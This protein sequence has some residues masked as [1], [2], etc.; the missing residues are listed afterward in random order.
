MDLSKNHSVQSEEFG[1]LNQK[2]IC[3]IILYWNSF[4]DTKNCIDSLLMDSKASH[5]IILVN[6]GSDNGS[7]ELLHQWL[8][9]QPGISINSIEYSLEK[10][11]Q[12]MLSS[13][14]ISQRVIESINIDR[15]LGFAG[16]NN[17]G[18]E[19]AL[20]RFGP[21]YIVLANNDTIIESGVISELTKRMDIERTIGV[22]GPTIIWTTRISRLHKSDI[23]VNAAHPV[24]T[25]ISG[26]FMII[27]KEVFDKAGRF[28][29][30]FFLYFEETDFFR[31]VRKNCYR[32]VLIPTKTKVLH[33]SSGSISMIGYKSLFHLG[34]SGMIYWRKNH[35]LEFF[36]FFTSVI[37]NSVILRIDFKGIKS[38]L[39]GII[40]GLES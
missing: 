29:N 13:E 35:S 12:K 40:A 6:N 11:F 1:S 2:K 8:E 9:Q 26:C 4:S 3:V 37:I 20:D 19:Y 36:N 32:V 18:I 10:G 38:L 23:Y 7:S 25:D 39:Q 33:K 14:D 30:D 16:G 15:N 22:A 27:R 31:R 17:V 34:R 28:D 5:R 24:D 21:D